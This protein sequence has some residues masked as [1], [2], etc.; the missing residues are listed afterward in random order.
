MCTPHAGETTDPTTDQGPEQIEMRG[1]VAAG[2]FLIVRQLGL[3]L[4]KEVLA[5]HRGHLGHEKP[6]CRERSSVPTL[7]SNGTQGRM[8]LLGS[9]GTRTTGINQPGVDWIG[10]HPMHG[11]LTPAHPPTR[12]G[13]PSLG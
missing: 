12:C 7:P 8:A 5:D 2:E 13:N 9:R 11:C 6:I 10:E 3:D 1:V 4:S